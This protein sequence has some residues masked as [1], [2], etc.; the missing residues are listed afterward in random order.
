M[1]RPKADD[2]MDTQVF[3]SR[4]RK[5]TYVRMATHCKRAGLVL[6]R[7]LEKA[8]TNALLGDKGKCK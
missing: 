1:G 7:W 5:D 4:L 6:W 3:S 2:F 8:V